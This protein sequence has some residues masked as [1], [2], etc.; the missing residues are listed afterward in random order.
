ML[1]VVSV[2]I[3]YQLIKSMCNPSKIFSTTILEFACVIQ[4]GRVVS[5]SIDFC[6]SLNNK[7]SKASNVIYLSFTYYLSHNMNL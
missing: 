1:F 2:L 4:R 6:Q 5:V 7:N 3:T